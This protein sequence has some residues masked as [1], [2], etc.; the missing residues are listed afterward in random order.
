MSGGVVLPCCFTVSCCSCCMLSA[1]SSKLKIQS[2]DS[3]A[4]ALAK[5][6]A[7]QF[8]FRSCMRTEQDTM[9]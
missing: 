3:V 4:G 1:I 2:I 5:D 6:D 7:T 8:A 9:M